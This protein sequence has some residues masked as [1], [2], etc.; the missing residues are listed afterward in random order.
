MRGGTFTGRAARRS[1]SEEVEQE[2][3][4]CREE[5]G[6]WTR[7]GAKALADGGESLRRVA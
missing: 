6:R 7:E 3:K 4:G 5:R 2:E 1:R